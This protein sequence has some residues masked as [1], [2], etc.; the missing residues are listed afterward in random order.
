M[1]HRKKNEQESFLKLDDKGNKEIDALEFIEF[2]VDLGFSKITV[3]K[4]FTLVR[5]E[6]NII[7]EVQSYEIGDTVREHLKVTNHISELR[8]VVKDKGLF[9][10]TNL[11]QLPTKEFEIQRD[12]EG[13][14]FLYFRNGFVSITTEVSGRDW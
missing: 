14:S 2:L 8:A 6:G 9:V 4:R 3:G 5:T 13:Q 10:R 11:Q 12:H 1:T 7:R